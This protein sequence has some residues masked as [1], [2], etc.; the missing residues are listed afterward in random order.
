M[1]IE[2]KAPSPGESI[3]EVILANWY[4][5]DGETV[6]KNETIAEIES[7]KATLD[8][9]ADETGILKTKVAEGET[10]S[11][12]S[13]VAII[14]K[15]EENFTDKLKQQETD[16]FTENSS[17][18]TA[19]NLKVEPQ[20][21]VKEENSSFMLRGKCFDVIIP[22]PGESIT[23]VQ[24][25]EWL[26]KDGD[27]VHKGEEILEIESEKAN[28]SIYADFSGILN[29]KM[30]QEEIANVGDIV[31]VIEEKKNKTTTQDI[32]SEEEPTTTT[33]DIPSEEEP[34]TTTQDIP[35]EEESTTIEIKQDVQSTTKQIA[36]PAA[37][38]MMEKENIHLEKGSGKEE[39]ITKGDVLE[40]IEKKANL[41]T[42]NKIQAI[43]QQ[44]K[45]IAVETVANKF[46]TAIP[47]EKKNTPVVEQNLI[48]RK[49][50]PDFAVHQDREIKEK[51][52]Q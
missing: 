22:S 24:I 36:S 12:G 35:S 13:V 26:K 49:L 23:Q 28:L 46:T 4:K 20:E 40:A 31:A 47:E 45:T 2:V 8:L 9:I 18:K 44:E 51:K 16:L 19:E 21:I 37:Q 32:P 48:S 33:Q 7:E 11:V 50:A 27:F 38:K 10:I 25:G 5:K 6:R 52:T 41:S 34:T 39:R 17:Q 14:E 15:T 30:K 3:S 43:K 29:I 42:E 1:E